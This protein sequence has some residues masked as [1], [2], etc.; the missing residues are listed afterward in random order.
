M[1]TLGCNQ[2]F[3]IEATILEMEL[4]TDEDGLLDV[5]DNCPATANK[6]QLDF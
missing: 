3:G 4:D 5:E 6:D 1:A 2:I